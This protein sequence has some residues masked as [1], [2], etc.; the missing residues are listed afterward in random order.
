MLN[1]IQK[2]E[3]AHER[4]PNHHWTQNH[5][6]YQKMD[7]VL[8]MIVDLANANMNHLKVRQFVFANMV[9]KTKTEIDMV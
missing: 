9:P 8:E 1:I 7:V 4:K 2:Q 5:Q 3:F 6:N